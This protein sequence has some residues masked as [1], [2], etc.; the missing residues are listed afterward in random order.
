MIK[1]WRETRHSLAFNCTYTLLFH[2]RILCGA[3]RETRH[4]C[5]FFFFFFFRA[6]PFFISAG[7]D[8][9]LLP[10]RTSVPIKA[11]TIFLCVSFCFFFF[12][13]FRSI[14]FHFDSTSRWT[15]YNT[16]SPWRL[17]YS[18]SLYERVEGKREGGATRN[19]L[20]GFQWYS[21]RLGQRGR[22]ETTS[23]LLVLYTVSGA[24]AQA[25]A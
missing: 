12:T 25:N 5:F 21:W 23:C 16:T 7:S 13:F 4:T 1:R 17:L 15:W 18:R 14:F 9:L 22:S 19:V 10:F 20:L 3:I 8:K 24:R 2:C 11:R 6:S